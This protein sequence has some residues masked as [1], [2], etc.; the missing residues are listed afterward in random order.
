M[1]L[2]NPAAD[3]PKARRVSLLDNSAITVLSSI[4][5]KPSH[6]A[7]PARRGKYGELQSWNRSQLE[8]YCGGAVQCGGEVVTDWM[9]PRQLLC[10]ISV[11]E[12]DKQPAVAL[13]EFTEQEHISGM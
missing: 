3:P 10:F 5:C 1:L 9:F 7:I 6:F 2:H 12:S 11:G 4:T 8:W 13:G